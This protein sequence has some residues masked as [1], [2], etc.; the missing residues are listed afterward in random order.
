MV[1]KLN[2][3]QFLPKALLGRFLLIIIVPTM[4]AQAIAVYIFYER[5]WASVGR[6]MAASLG[7]E[8]TTL[9]DLAENMPLKNQQE[10]I[11][12]GKDLGFDTT[13]KKDK[14]F[15]PDAEQ[16]NYS[17]DRALLARELKNRIHHPFTIAEYEDENYEKFYI[18]RIDFGNQLLRIKVSDKR[19]TNSSSYIFIM[20]MVG[21]AGL[22]LLVSIVFLHNQIKFIRL[23]ADAAEGF[24]KGQEIENFK[25]RGAL[26]VRQAALAF[27]KMQERIK[28]QTQQRTAM[29]AGISHDLRTPLTRM[30]LQLALLKNSEEA[31]NL[32]TDI[33]EMEKMIEGYINFAKGQ[34]TEESSEIKISALLESVVENYKRQGKNIQ[35]KPGSKIEQPIKLRENAMR[36]MFG[37]ILG[38]AFHYGDSVNIS[39]ENIGNSIIIYIDDN[40]PGISPEMREE[41]FKPFF[42][43]DLSAI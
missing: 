20:W 7:A 26:E 36:R 21:S 35:L 18:I 13:I 16:K 2:I 24:G 5:H 19:L 9:T 23:F 28:R 8:I 1:S 29:L 11:K 12:A 27:I 34:E 22:L 15:P 30:K 38:N 25:P 14:K 42:R 17:G 6:N 4:L 32:S 40:G 43:M 31:G 10:V 37:N 33:I 39:T 41:V 3:K